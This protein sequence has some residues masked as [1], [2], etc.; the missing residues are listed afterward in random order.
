M[1]NIK[2]LEKKCQIAF[3]KAVRT[4]TV[5]TCVEWERLEDEYTTQLKHSIR[6]SD[7]QPSDSVC[8]TDD[9]SNEKG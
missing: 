5:Q 9:L 6:H 7:I 1:I 4:K 3:Q 8:D 2:E